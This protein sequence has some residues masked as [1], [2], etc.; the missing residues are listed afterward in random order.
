MRNI[1]QEEQSHI[2]F[3]CRVCRKKVNAYSVKKGDCAYRAIAHEYCPEVMQ[4][5]K[6]LR[7]AS[8]ADVSE[9]FRASLEASYGKEKA[10]KM[11]KTAWEKEI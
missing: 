9:L 5:L 3:A 6:E 2:D 8:E 1:N 4:A 7:G 10:Q 11:Y